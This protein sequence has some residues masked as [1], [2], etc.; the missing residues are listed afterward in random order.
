LR[1]DWVKNE[2]SE[3]EKH[4]ILVPVL[5]EKGIDQPLQFRHIQCV[6]L[7][8]WSGDTSHDAYCALVRALVSLID[9]SG[10]A[11][12]TSGNGGSTEAKH[13]LEPVGFAARISSLRTL[14]PQSPLISVAIGSGAV[15]VALGVLS[16]YFNRSAVDRSNRETLKASASEN[17]RP[18]VQLWADSVQASSERINE[19]ERHPASAAFDGN[20][21][22]AWNSLSST[23]GKPE[24]LG[25]T[26]S[27]R[28]YLHHVV[29]YNGYQFL[30]VSGESLFFKNFRAKLMEVYV[31]DDTLPVARAEFGKMDQTPVA[32]HIRH[33]AQKVRFV[34]RETWEPDDS[35]IGKYRDVCISEIEFWGSREPKRQ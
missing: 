32:I 23:E 10:N 16:A 18:V 26:F 15:L 17:D 7:A 6:D 24:W 12:P 28:V 3:G 30:L 14:R 2:A 11:V 27:D 29:V 5:V 9:R 13:S 20:R 35:A 4:R 8:D 21:Q 33:V 22:S 1:S 31:D 34:I 25:A 19:Q